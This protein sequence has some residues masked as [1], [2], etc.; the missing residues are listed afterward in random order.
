[1]LALLDST[2]SP[3][4]APATGLLRLSDDVGRKGW[5]NSYANT[6]DRQFIDLPWLEA[7]AERLRTY[8]AMLVPGP[9]VDW[10]ISTR[11]PDHCATAPAES[12]SAT[13]TTP[14]AP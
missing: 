4:S 12:R 11:R 13:A 1:M 6:V 5:W 14:I 10:H 3:R 9:K 7:R 8:G 2:A